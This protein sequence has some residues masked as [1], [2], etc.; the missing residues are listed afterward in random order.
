MWKW[1]LR[2]LQNWIY[3]EQF[4][5]QLLTRILNRRLQYMYL[6]SST[7]CNFLGGCSTCID[8]TNQVALYSCKEGYIM[9]TSNNCENCPNNS[10]I[11]GSTSI[12]FQCQYNYWNNGIVFLNYNVLLANN[13]IFYLIII[14]LNVSCHFIIVLILPQNAFY[15][16]FQV[17]SLGS[18]GYFVNP[19]L[20]GSKYQILSISQIYKNGD[21]FTDCAS[22]FLMNTSIPN[23]CIHP[24]KTYEVQK[25]TYN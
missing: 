2:Y 9:N 15:V 7:K 4:Q 14:A 11:C 8:I 13:T 20:F 25:T 3:V 24:N 22:T 17:K 18:N 12:C 5:V 23:Q 1:N 19:S 21:Y 6:I 10:K 16:L